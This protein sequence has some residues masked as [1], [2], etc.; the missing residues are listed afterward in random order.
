M[1]DLLEIVIPT[2]SIVEIVIRGSLGFLALVALLRIVPKRN[3]GHISPNDMLVLI[4]VGAMGADAVTGGSYSIGDIVMM[5]AVVLAW[6]YILDVLEYRFPWMG[7]ILRNDATRLVEN[8]RMLKRNMRRELVTVDELMSALR[9]EGIPDLSFVRLAVLEAD[10][11][12]SFIT[13]RE[14]GSGG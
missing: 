4:V 8:G 13:Y 1:T 9:R 14:P 3:A 11:E 7:R 5:I 12:I 6:G 2:K 10:G